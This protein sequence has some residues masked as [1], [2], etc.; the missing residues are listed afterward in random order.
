MNFF[1]SLEELTKYNYSLNGYKVNIEM[2]F[3]T[4]E[5]TAN[6]NQTGTPLA[7]QYLPQSGLTY[8]DSG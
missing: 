1:Q 5:G 2:C 6:E 3:F 8:S 7:F 4:V